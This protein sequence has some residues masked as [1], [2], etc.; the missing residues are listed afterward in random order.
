[1]VTRPEIIEVPQVTYAPMPAELT[2]PLP[3]PAVPPQRCTDKHGAPAWCLV[4][5]LNWIEDWRTTLHAANDDRARVA[6][7]SA[8]AA[9]AVQP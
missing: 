8:A 5:A 4:D 6:R 2:R 9:K 1:V 3:E 7:I